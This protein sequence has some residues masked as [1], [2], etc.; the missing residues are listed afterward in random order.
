MPFANIDAELPVKMTF[1]RVGLLYQLLDIPPPM[2][3][4]LPLKVTFVNV[5]FVSGQLN[6]PPP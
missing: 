1:V 5:G 3:A 2:V 6:I 4:E